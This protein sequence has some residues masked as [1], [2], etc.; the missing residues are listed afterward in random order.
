MYVSDLTEFSDHCFLAI[1]I[2]I[3]NKQ[4]ANIDK[5][6]GIFDLGIRG[7]E[8][9]IRCTGGKKGGIRLSNRGYL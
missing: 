1:S 6:F 3:N 9:I 4:T 5:T 2:N 7:I 8:V